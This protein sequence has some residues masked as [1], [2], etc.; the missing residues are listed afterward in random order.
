MPSEVVAEITRQHRLTPESF[1]ILEG[2]TEIT[3]PD[4]KSFFLI[5]P[6]ATSDDVRNAALL[7]YVLDAAGDCRTAR[8]QRTDFPDP[9]YSATEVQRI[10][11]RQQAN[12][13]SY[14]HDVGFVHRNGGQLVTTPN[15]MLMGLGG[16]RI[17]RQFSR[18]GGTTWGDIFLV[19]VSDSA[20]HQLRRIVQSGH[21]WYSDGNGKPVQGRLALDRILRHEERHCRQWAANGHARMIRAYIWEVIRDKVFGKTNRLEEDA[22]LCDG[23]YL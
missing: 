16:N 12:S 8:A 7:T 13:W 4:G 11:E 14:D 3:D 21:F 10:I 9:P 15:G 1:T 22:G 20:G 23:G 5:P 6:D 17:Q 18:L 2:F 19:N